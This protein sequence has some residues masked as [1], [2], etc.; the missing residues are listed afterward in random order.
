[1]TACAKAPSFAFAHAPVFRQGHDQ[2]RCQDPA[3][4]HLVRDDTGR[5]PRTPSIGSILDLAAER[6]A[7]RSLLRSR[8]PLAPLSP[9]PATR[10]RPGDEPK[11]RATPRSL[12]LPR[13][14]PRLEL[15]EDAPHRLLQPT[16]DTST[17]ELL[18]Y[19]ARDFRRVDPAGAS[20]RAGSG[21][22]APFSNERFSCAAPN[23]LSAIRPRLAWRLTAQ[24][25]LRLLATRWSVLPPFRTARR[26]VV[27][28]GRP[29]HGSVV[30]S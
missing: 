12:G 19:R 11:V 2:P 1:V 20:Q 9:E 13:G 25:Q 8:E 27:R 28:V 22:E 24:V 6:R 10:P 7:S 23:H 30:F 17:R 3:R 5:E 16:Y 21:T 26:R 29:R 18:D 4:S 15:G 14:S